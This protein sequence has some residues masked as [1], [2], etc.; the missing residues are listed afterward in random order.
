MTPVLM[1]RLVPHRVVRPDKRDAK[2]QLSLN[3]LNF[4]PQRD[5]QSIRTS[6]WA[7]RR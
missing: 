2:V 4:V 5:V 7:N 6:P 3:F 1:A